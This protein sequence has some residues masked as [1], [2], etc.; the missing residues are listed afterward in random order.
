[1]YLKAIKVK[2]Q[3]SILNKTFII[4]HKGKDYCVDYLN[5][6]GHTLGLLNRDCWEVTDESRENVNIYLFKDSTKKQKEEV[7]KNIRLV[8][9]LISF[10][11]KHFDDY[12]FKL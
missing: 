12:K 8:R 3:Q 5:S 4:N 6:D 1:M 9:E 2:L 11:I 7:N 10:C